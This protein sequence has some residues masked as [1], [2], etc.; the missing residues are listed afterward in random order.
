MRMFDVSHR[1]AWARN[2]QFPF[3]GFTAAV[4]V[5]MARAAGA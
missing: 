3:G 4:I 2:R 5:V 1:C